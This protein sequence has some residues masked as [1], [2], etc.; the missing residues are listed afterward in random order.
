[1][2]T[3]AAEKFVC[4]TKNAGD[5]PALRTFAD[6]KDI[7]SSGTPA[8]W[9]AVEMQRILSAIG[10]GRTRLCWLPTGMNSKSDLTGHPIT[11][12]DVVEEGGVVVCDAVSDAYGIATQIAALSSNKEFKAVRAGKTFAM[13]IYH[14]GTAKTVGALVSDISHSTYKIVDGACSTSS[15]QWIALLEN[16]NVLT[17]SVTADILAA[18]TLASTAAIV[19]VGMGDGWG[20]LLHSDGYLTIVGSL[21]QTAAMGDVVRRSLAGTLR[22]GRR[23]RASGRDPERRGRVRR[24]RRRRGLWMQYRW[25][26]RRACSMYWLPGAHPAKSNCLRRGRSLSELR[27]G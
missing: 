3:G 9:K 18:T 6:D 7:I 24:G 8:D 20:F 12:L 19:S 15:L 10:Y 14:N 11:W 16:G 23:A 26:V 5:F 22:P 4:E 1:M 25:P 13:L 17:D 2:V 21:P 27:D